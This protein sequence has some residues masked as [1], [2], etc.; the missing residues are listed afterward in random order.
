MTDLTPEEMYGGGS[1]APHNQIEALRGHGW[2]VK[3]ATASL[4]PNTGWKVWLSWRQGEPPHKEESKRC[5]TL[6]EAAEWLVRTAGSWD[7]EDS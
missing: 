6:I 4:G 5:A 1:L 2:F 3:L 7:Y